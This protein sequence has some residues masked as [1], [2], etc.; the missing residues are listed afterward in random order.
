MYDK[1]LCLVADAE[2]SVSLLGNPQTSD[3]ELVDTAQLPLSEDHLNRLRARGMYY[4]GVTGLVGG[5]PRTAL[6]EGL[7][8]SDIGALTSAF[9]AYLATVL[10][11][12]QKPAPSPAVEWVAELFALEDP[13]T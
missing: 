3:F 2:L 13:R 10:Q 11:L 1:Q 9:L 8:H 12:P 5:T 7:S 4:L 6:I